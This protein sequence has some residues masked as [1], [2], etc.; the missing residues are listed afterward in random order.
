MASAEKSKRVKQS[1]H[2]SPR[3][4]LKRDKKV[5][6]SNAWEEREKNEGGK[7]SRGTEPQKHQRGKK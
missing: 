1:P 7:G 6:P 5:A 3:D 4:P 2:L